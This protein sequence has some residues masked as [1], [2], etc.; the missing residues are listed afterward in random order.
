MFASVVPQW[1]DDVEILLAANTNQPGFVLRINVVVCDAVPSQT[2]MWLP[3]IAY[4]LKHHF[5]DLL[6]VIDEPTEHATSTGFADGAPLL[7]CTLLSSE[8]EYAAALRFM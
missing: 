6:N 2:M 4:S 1:T 7:G 3:A 5:P 8:G